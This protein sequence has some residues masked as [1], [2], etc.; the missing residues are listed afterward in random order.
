MKKSAVLVN[1]SRG[2]LIDE[3][4]VVE[5]VREGRIGGV[6]LDVFWEE[7]LSEES[8]WRKAGEWAKSEVVL[9]PHMGY[10]NKGTMERWYQEQGE[11]VRRY[12][13]GEEAAFRMS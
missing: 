12:M 9:S 6:A 13:A 1:T 11:E 4:A 5:V 2:P 8:V 7:P 3:E 10:A